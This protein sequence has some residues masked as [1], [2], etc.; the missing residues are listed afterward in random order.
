[1]RANLS[2]NSTVLG[3]QMQSP[4]E[5]AGYRLFR[6]DAGSG[7][8]IKPDG[9]IVSV[10]DSPSEPRGSSYA[11]LQ[12]AV[13]AGGNKANVF[14]TYL[15]DIYQEVGF[16][17]VARVPW[18]DQ[19]APPDWDKDAFREYNNGQPDIMFFVHDPNYF[20]ESVDV[21]YAKNYDDAVRMQT[22]ALN[23]LSPQGAEVPNAAVNTPESGRP[24]KKG[25]M[26]ELV[27]NDNRKYF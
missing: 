15:S 18:N 17:P 16:R 5:I 6:T 7:F 22:N 4:E 11:M 2:R 3:G 13:Q 14:D 10:F 19:F 25:G 20:G 12:A 24:F 1:M 8:A 26:V 23:R 27:T 9:N 21:P